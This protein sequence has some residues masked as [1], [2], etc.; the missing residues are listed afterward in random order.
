MQTSD[1]GEPYS[2]PWTYRKRVI[3]LRTYCGRV[4]HDSR[5]HYFKMKDADRILRAIVVP[6]SADDSWMTEATRLLKAGTLEMLGKIL[7]FFGDDA[8][9][10]VYDFILGIVQKIMYGGTISKSP[11]SIARHLIQAIA[12]E[13]R[14]KVT[15]L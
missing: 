5:T 4:V 1:Y 13:A 15:I 12:E 3:P 10:A 11:E 8:V 6:E 2:E 9:E 14:L 7:W